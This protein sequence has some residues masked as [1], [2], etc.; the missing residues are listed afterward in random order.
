MMFF[1]VRISF[2][3]ILFPNLPLLIQWSWE[4]QCRQNEKNKDR[5]RM[6]RVS[7]QLKIKVWFTFS[8]L[9]SHSYSRMIT[10]DKENIKIFTLSS[11]LLT[12]L[13]NIKFSKASAMMNSTYFCLC[14]SRKITNEMLNI[15]CDTDTDCF[16]RSFR[17][18]SYVS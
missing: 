7:Q 14:Q 17:I 18:R 5:R 4:S 13:P 10:Q 15:S 9:S 2:L 11:Y 1:R 8:C 16:E 6:H 12:L 3:M